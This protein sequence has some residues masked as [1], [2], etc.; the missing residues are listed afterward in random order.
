LLLWRTQLEDDEEEGKDG[1]WAF[2]VVGG[3]AHYI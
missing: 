3:D 1:W 2:F